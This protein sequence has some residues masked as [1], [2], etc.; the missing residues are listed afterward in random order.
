MSLSKLLIEGIRRGYVELT[1]T[2]LMPP[3]IQTGVYLGL[4][5]DVVDKYVAQYHAKE[6]YWRRYVELR[7]YSGVKYESK[8]WYGSCKKKEKSNE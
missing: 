6:D 4:D 8:T 5:D 7:F 2:D 3:I 1:D